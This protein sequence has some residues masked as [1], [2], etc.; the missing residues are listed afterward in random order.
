MSGGRREVGLKNFTGKMIDRGNVSDGKRKG[1]LRDVAGKMKDRE[2]VSDGR[3]SVAE[4]WTSGLRMRVASIMVGKGSLR[5]RSAAFLHVCA[6]YLE[7][8]EDVI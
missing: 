7:I 5:D 1:E 2:N 6:G 4:S 8:D 3:M